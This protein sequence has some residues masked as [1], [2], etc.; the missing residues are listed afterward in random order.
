MFKL[1]HRS[2]KEQHWRNQSDFLHYEIY[3]E[4]F[5]LELFSEA[6]SSLNAHGLK[7]NDTRGVLKNSLKNIERVDGDF[8]K[9]KVVELKKMKEEGIALNYKAMF[10]NAE[11][12]LFNEIYKDDI[13]LYKSYFGK[14][15]L[16]F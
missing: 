5:S 16:L 2:E 1:Q 9:I 6:I 12:K 4:Y 15:G 14:S 13:N 3:D 10:S 7:V 8:S 11:I